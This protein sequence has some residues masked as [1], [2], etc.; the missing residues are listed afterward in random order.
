MIV[1]ILTQRQDVHNVRLH[2]GL[3]VKGHN[4]VKT[5]IAALEVLLS[6]FLGRLMAQLSSSRS[7]HVH[8]INMVIHGDEETRQRLEHW[9]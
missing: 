2:A 5:F 6:P 1:V 9:Q 7:V 8:D 3:S 4:F